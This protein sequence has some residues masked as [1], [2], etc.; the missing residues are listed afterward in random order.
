[1]NQQF[2]NLVTV[3][4][5]AIELGLSPKSLR[6]R[7]RDNN[8]PKPSTRWEWNEDDE[9]VKLIRSWKTNGKRKQEAPK[10]PEEQPTYIEGKK[11]L[12]AGLEYTYSNGSFYRGNYSLEIN[13]VEG[14]VEE[15]TG[16]YEIYSKGNWSVWKD[17]ETKAIQ[18]VYQGPKS[19][20]KTPWITEASKIRKTLPKYVKEAMIEALQ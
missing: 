3:K 12:I 11:Y 6:K 1:M 19:T 9:V 5:L 15:I 8:I 16:P 4:E 10:K 13:L 2:E 7:I 14:T 20:D 18:A 17:P